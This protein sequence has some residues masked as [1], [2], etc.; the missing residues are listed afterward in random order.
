MLL[1]HLALGTAQL[2]LP[3]GIADVQKKARK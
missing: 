2:G 3:Y 1:P